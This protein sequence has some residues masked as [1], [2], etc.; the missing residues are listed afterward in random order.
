[1]CDVRSLS[2]S[3]IRTSKVLV[4]ITRLKAKL[5]VGIDMIPNYIIKNCANVLAPVL[6]HTFNLSLKI[7]MFSSPWKMNVAIPVYKKKVLPV[8]WKTIDLYLCYVLFRRSL[9]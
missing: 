3:C 2:I 9:R 8:D 5:S 4:V 6:C 1:M 7:N